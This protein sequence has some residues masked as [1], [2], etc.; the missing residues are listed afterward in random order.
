MI[1]KYFRLSDGNPHDFAA[2]D[3]LF[4][5]LQKAVFLGSVST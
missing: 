3:V 1:R 4:L 2:K 5:V